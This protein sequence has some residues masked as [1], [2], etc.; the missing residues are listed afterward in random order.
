LFPGSAEPVPSLLQR[1][2]RE[3][4]LHVLLIGATLFVVYYSLTR[5][6]VDGRVAWGD[7]QDIHYN[8]FVH[9]FTRGRKP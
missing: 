6:E 4:L 5:W 3:P 9:E 1:W 2:L 7:C 8:R